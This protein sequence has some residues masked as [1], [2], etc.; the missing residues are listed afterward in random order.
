MVP[1]ATGVSHRVLFFNTLA[2]TVCFAAWMLNGVLVTFLADNKIFSWNAVEVGWLLGIPVLSGSLFRLPAGMLADKYGGKWVFGLLLLGC[3]VPAFLLGYSNSFFSFAILSFLLGFTGTSFAVGISVSSVWY[4][5]NFQGTAL[6]IFGIG[7]A[8]A[9]LTTL[10]APALL[11]YFTLNSLEGWRIL[12]KCYACLL[13]LT[14]VFYL[15]FTENKRPVTGNKTW[16]EM[17]RPLK[18]LRVWRFGLYY[19]LVFGCFVAFSQWLVPY[20][21]NVYSVSLVAAGI[22]ASVFS[23]PSGIIRAFGG[24][25]SDRWGARKVMS[26]V[27][28]SSFIIC[29]L[30]VF[31]RMEIY[32]PGKGVIA[33]SQG[34]VN[35]VSDSLIIVDET[36]YRLKKQKPFSLFEKK[37]LLLPEKTSWH[38]PVIEKGDKVKRK[39]LLAKGTT[40]IYFDANLWIFVTLV[41]LAGISW[42]IGKAAVYKYIPDFF[43]EEVGTVGGLVG[44]IGGLGGFFCSVLF[45]YALECTGLWTSCWMLMLLL[46]F[47]CLF[48][49]RVAVKKEGE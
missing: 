44:V 45:G 48:W 43:P 16:S 12:P 4:P 35:F 3:A 5:K 14:A 26:F 47:I 13:A 18:S 8:G 25:L 33:S 38:Q 42:G 39:Q 7:N 23:F 11:N 15:L 17:L 49:M 41:F 29:L 28:G 21:I 37:T 19:F 2:F 34:T 46:S 32:S 27:L 30:L 40:A 36:L 22:F 24:W 20:F 31:P 10:A 9:A 6:G 1:E